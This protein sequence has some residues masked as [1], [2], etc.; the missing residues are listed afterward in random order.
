MQCIGYTDRYVLAIEICYK[1][2]ERLF[3]TGVILVSGGWRGV[4]VQLVGVQLAAVGGR[5]G[6]KSRASQLRHTLVIFWSPETQKLRHTLN[7]F[8]PAEIQ[9]LWKTLEEYN[10]EKDTFELRHT[11]GN[12]NF[13]NTSDHLCQLQYSTVDASVLEAY[14]NI[15]TTKGTLKVIQSLFQ[16]TTVGKVQEKW[17]LKVTLACNWKP[18]KPLKEKKNILY[19][20]RAFIM[21][22]TILLFIVF[23]ALVRWLTNDHQISHARFSQNQKLCLDNF[24]YIYLQNFCFER[25]FSEWL[26][27]LTFIWPQFF[28]KLFNFRQSHCLV[29]YTADSGVSLESKG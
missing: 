24:I 18:D 3:I 20:R 7:I 21:T 19:L 15:G 17:T 13:C 10:F 26:F 29:L 14:S 6:H 8:W 9:K 22:M 11:L 1:E 25:R 28:I 23:S 4:E 27:W 16:G 5:R 2:S 12:R